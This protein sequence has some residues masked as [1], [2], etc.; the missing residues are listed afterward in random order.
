MFNTQM[1]EWIKDTGTDI[2]LED[3]KTYLNG[4]ESQL[5]SR[6][7]SGAPGR[8]ITDIYTKGIDLFIK[9]L[10][11]DAL[12]RFL[13]GYTGTQSCLVAIGGYGRGELNPRSDIDLMLLYKGRLDKSIESIC[14]KL[15]YL[16]WDT[17]LD[18]GFSIRSVKE[19]I[20]LA[21]SDSKTMTS[22]LD[23]RL[24]SGNATV[25]DT[26]LSRL[27]RRVITPNKKRLIDVKL[28]ES[29]LRQERYGGS[30]YILE[31]NVKEGKGGLR[32]IHT[33][34]WISRIKERGSNLD[35]LVHKGIITLDEKIGIEES[36]DF[37]LRIRN[38]LHF[39]NRKKVDQLTFDSQERISALFGYTD[40]GSSLGVESFMRD[41]YLH[42]NRI[43][44]CSTILISRLTYKSVTPLKE[45]KERITG[46]YVGRWCRIHQGMIA[47]KVEPPIDDT[48]SVFFDVFE[49]AQEHGL[50]IHPL[51]KEWIKRNLFLIDDDFRRSPIYNKRFLNIIG[52]RSGVYEALNN[53][54]S[55]GFL[56]RYIP[57]FEN[58]T[59]KVQHD[60]YHIYTV[61]VHSLF[62]VR[63]L[64][65]LS[66]D[67]Y[68]YEFPLL[69][70][71]IEG[72]KRFELLV[73]ATLLHDIGKS[74]GKG[75]AERGGS[76]VETILERMGLS[77]DD[78]DLVSFLVANHLLLADIA[79]HRDIHDLK[80]I[81]EIARKVE[82]IDR[83]NMLYLLTFADVRA[84]GP[85]VWTQWKA[86]LFQELYFRVRKVIDKGTFELPGI[87]EEME[88]I[89][90]AIFSMVSDSLSSEAI[91]VYMG[92]FPFRYYLS[93]PVEDL[94]LHIHILEGF[95]DTGLITHIRHDL[96]RAY[97][98]L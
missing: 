14:K 90:R 72:V 18:I 93:N 94:A 89:G 4:L 74:G 67:R 3:A 1:A 92:R 84:V 8:Q 41:Y 97:T 35:S 60:L 42:A 66:T 6:H 58:V 46:R 30:V 48:P 86:A 95:D 65:L 69:V 7:L 12:K 76:I 28:N 19:S 10:Y 83:L 34:L 20:D 21:C 80:L 73:L 17:G 40:T 81:V 5:L 24:I 59:F 57:E 36:V 64:E 29:R 25:Y 27:Y 63:E 52:R 15:L 37:L 32:D 9:R 77:E 11:E 55:V 2:T 47:L 62:A 54:H 88:R 16:L 71:L 91:E 43:N 49:A 56:G 96:E 31:P 75:H 38:D 23:S 26:F 44:Y 39:T 87:D 45:L 13:T 98:E 82:D 51:T 61:D 85:D 22:F 79:Q 50:E 78:T 70:S 68:R 33:A 53:M